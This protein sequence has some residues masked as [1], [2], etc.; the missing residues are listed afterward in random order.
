MFGMWRAPGFESFFVKKSFPSYFLLQ[1]AIRLRVSELELEVKCVFCDF[2]MI[3][4][5]LLS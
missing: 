1:V 4:R 2:E 5:Y 3:A